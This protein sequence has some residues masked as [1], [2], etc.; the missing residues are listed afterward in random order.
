[1]LRYREKPLER[2]FKVPLASRGALA[3]FIAC[4]IALCMLLM[5]LARVR[6]QI[7]GVGVMVLAAIVYRSVPPLERSLPVALEMIAD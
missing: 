2:P 4:P 3:V 7:V 1:M 5:T 6:T